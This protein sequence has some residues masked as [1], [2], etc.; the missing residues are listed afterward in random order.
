MSTLTTKNF[1][2]A[3]S[4]VTFG[5]VA[6][7]MATLTAHAASPA[8]ADTT[9]VQTVVSFSDLDLSKEADAKKLYARLQRASDHVCR[10]RKDV[11]NLALTRLQD[12]CYQDT[13]ARAVNN[14]GHPAVKAVFAADERIKLASRSSKRAART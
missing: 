2:I 10:D 14:V 12:A 11:R 1:R 3:R 7:S 8:V 9:S 6:L 4:V 13:L 5:A